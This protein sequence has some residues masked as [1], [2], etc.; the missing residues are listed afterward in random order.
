MSKQAAATE[1]R[2][3]AHSTFSME[4]TYPASPARVFTA[5]ADPAVKR[6]WFAEGEGFELRAYTLDFRV[7]GREATDSCFK[8]APPPGHSS[9]EMRNETVYLD[10]VPDRRIVL[11]YTMAIGGQRFSASQATFELL[12]DGDGTRLV[13]TEQ[14]AFFEGADG[15]VMREQGW[16]AL[17]E[18]LGRELAR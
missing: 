16:R 11:A 3:V 12:P 7:G 1:A 9:R 2:T 5:F 13:F 8:G 18:S 4:R 15:P 6:R 10:I 14:A 17:L